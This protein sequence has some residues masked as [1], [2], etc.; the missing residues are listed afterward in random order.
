[1]SQDPERPFSL[2]HASFTPHGDAGDQLLKERIIILGELDA[3]AAQLAVAQL[4]LL[5]RDDP[6]APVTVYVNTATAP[7]DPAVSL[8]DAIQMVSCPVAT[9]CTG[10]AA[11]AAVL[12]IAAGARGHR[13]ALPHARFVL[14]MPRALDLGGDVAALAEEVARSRRT[15]VELLAGVSDNPPEAVRSDLERGRFLTARQAVE[16]GVI[17][18]VLEQPPKAWRAVLTR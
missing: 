12:V 8:H 5:E 9:V 16:Y 17:D 6:A 15:L 11:E 4:L 2:G 14:R 10:V 1:M 7:I 13:V 3:G 18:E